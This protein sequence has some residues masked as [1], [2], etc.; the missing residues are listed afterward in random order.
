MPP[1]ILDRLSLVHMVSLP[2]DDIKL[3]VLILEDD[4]TDA[5]LMATLLT[6]AI[7]GCQFTRV[8]TQSAF[9]STLTSESIDIIL[10]DYSLPSFD[11]IE[12]IK[13]AQ[14]ICP[15]VPVI[16]VSGV[17][18]EERAIDALKSGATDYVLKQRMERLVPAVERAIKE[19]E[20][21]RALRQAT[22]EQRK[23]EQR[24]RTLT[25][26]M[27]DPLA[28]VVAQQ[29]Q[30]FIRDLTVSHLNKA[31]CS[32]LSISLEAAIG[33][34]IYTVVPAFSR[35]RTVEDDR[36]F[37]QILFG[38]LE[39]GLS[40]SEEIV[41]T[42]SHGT[43]QRVVIDIRAAKLN[44]NGIVLNWRDVTERYTIAEQRQRLLMEAEAARSDA[45]QANQ[46]KENLLATVSH[47]LKSPLSVIKGW[48]TIIEKRPEET[49]LVTQALTVMDKNAELLDGLIENLLDA[50]RAAVGKLAFEPEVISFEK[51]KQAI[52]KT[53]DAINLAA[54]SK[55]ISI[56][57][58]VKPPMPSHSLVVGEQPAHSSESEGQGVLSQYI[59][60]DIV[61]LQ[62]V[63]RHLL[64]NAVKFT[65]AKGKV[66][67]TLHSKEDAITI[68]VKDTGRGIEA[69]ELP[70]IFERFWQAH[71]AA[72]EDKQPGAKGLGIG[73]AIAHHIVELHRGRIR[74]SSDGQ[75]KGST[76]L[77]EL[78]TLLRETISDSSIEIDKSTQSILSDPINS[79]PISKADASRLQGVKVLV[80]EDFVDALE[81]YQ[82]MLEV[83]GA[84]VKGATSTESAMELFESFRPDILI[85]DI[86]LP[87]SDGYTLIRKIRARSAEAGGQVPAIALT[88]LSE[89]KHRTKA[90]LAGFQMHVAKPVGMHEIVKVVAQL[91]A[92]Q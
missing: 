76:F 61:R 62:Q 50:S 41:L 14:E 81:V 56:S 72:S 55:Q 89:D 87:S 37:S 35:A 73:L 28:V 30:G 59:M 71:S 69:A 4:I 11:G 12:A 36:S 48:L 51:L 67:V 32:Y 6:K 2:S 63:V 52:T 15:D 8:E 86:S 75:E 82:L 13:I 49:G 77:I 78:P 85:S 25:E 5:E 40:Q 31:A 80:I 54:S 47:E 68:S 92:H 21:R 79:T 65:P 3:N 60:G 18:G 17:L 45:E 19:R 90:L 58:Q 74:V 20:A 83:Y 7:S 33:Q 42:G 91:L 22:L 27:A 26:T 10:A 64:A 70:H 29:E 39:T 38:I 9:Y 46:F 43:G 84:D 24:F 53:I 16:L 57:F 23:S 34:S 88:A 1:V 66:D 44:D